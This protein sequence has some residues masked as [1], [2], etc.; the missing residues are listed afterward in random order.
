MT[1][2]LLTW[3]RAQLDDDE[4]VARKATSAPWLVTASTDGTLADVVPVTS[5]FEDY[6]CDRDDAEHIARWNP[7]RVLAE[8]A[9]KRRI[10]QWVQDRLVDAEDFP[11]NDAYRVEAIEATVLH[12]RWLAAPYAGREGYRD[13]W[14]PVEE[15][16]R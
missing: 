14:K 16:T 12:L 5:S 13:E 8:V 1:D 11:Q 7:D 2:D 4:Q 6:C 15:A 3:L 10:L 9:H